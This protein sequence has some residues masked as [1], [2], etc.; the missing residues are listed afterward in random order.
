MACIPDSGK[1]LATSRFRYPKIGS[2]VS[3]API[4]GVI[5]RQWMRFRRLEVAPN[6]SDCGVQKAM[7][8]MAPMGLIKVAATPSSALSAAGGLRH[9]RRRRNIALG[10][11][12]LRPSAGR[13]GTRVFPAPPT[14]ALNGQDFSDKR[15]LPP[16]PPVFREALREYVG[17]ANGTTLPRLKAAPPI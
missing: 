12:Q 3:G 1:Y 7:L 11:H 10:R 4:T 9:R 13:S 17:G 15:T 16:R 6:V 2:G 14:A 5:H 8:R